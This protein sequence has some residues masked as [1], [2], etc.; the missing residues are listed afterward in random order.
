MVTGSHIDTQPTGGKFDG[1][2][3]VPDLDKIP[4]IAEKRQEKWDMIDK[5]REL[6]INERREAKGYAPIETVVP[7]ENGNR[8]L[9]PERAEAAV[10]TAEG[11]ALM[12]RLGYGS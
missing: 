6:T 10:N 2:Y 8:L 5:S 3:L 9:G 1:A 4:A 12:A 7:T 11:K